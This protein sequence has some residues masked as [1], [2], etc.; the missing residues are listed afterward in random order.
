MRALAQIDDVTGIQ[1]VLDRLRTALNDIDEQPTTGIV[2][3]AA[4]LS[5]DIGG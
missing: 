2:T 3:L 5:R 1:A 4:E